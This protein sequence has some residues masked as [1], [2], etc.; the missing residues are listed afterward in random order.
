MTPEQ[1]KKAVEL[2][3]YQI[4]TLSPNAQKIATAT[5]DTLVTRL[6]LEQPSISQYVR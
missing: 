3:R 6:R 4:S 1:I 2:T 5:L